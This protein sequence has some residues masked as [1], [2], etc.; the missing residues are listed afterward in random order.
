MNVVRRKSTEAVQM[1]CLSH[2]SSHSSFSPKLMSCWVSHL[3][4]KSG[5]PK[6][7][8]VVTADIVC[9]ETFSWKQLVLD[10]SIAIKKSFLFS[11]M[12]HN[13]GYLIMGLCWSSAVWC[14]WPPLALDLGTFRVLAPGCSWFTG[15]EDL[16]IAVMNMLFHWWDDFALGC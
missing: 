11:V 8:S 5:K 10:F 2:Y 12:S 16:M 14:L 7:T 3:D 1:H 15:T 9:A 4:L 13:S 6:T